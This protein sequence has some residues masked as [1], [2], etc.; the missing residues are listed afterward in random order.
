MNNDDDDLDPGLDY[1]K[2]GLGVCAGMIIFYIVMS[3]IISIYS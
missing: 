1:F 2:M 3:Y